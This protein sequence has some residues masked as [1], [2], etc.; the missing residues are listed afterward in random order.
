MAT[1]YTEEFKRDAIIG[2]SIQSLVSANALRIWEL[3]KEP[4][5][6]GERLMMRTTVP[7][8]PEDVAIMKAM[9]QKKLPV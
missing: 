3:A 5:L 6:H 7:Y 8:Q 9:K 4:C 2:R 1:Q